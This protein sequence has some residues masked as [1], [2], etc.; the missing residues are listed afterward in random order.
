MKT[1]RRAVTRHAFFSRRG[2]SRALPAALGLVLLLGAGACQPSDAKDFTFQPVETTNADFEPVTFVT[3]GNSPVAIA[4]ADA[5][6][7]G[8]MDVAVINQFETVTE[9]GTAADPEQ[10]GTLMLFLND[11]T[12][13]LTLS[14]E[15]NAGAL[16]SR[17]LFAHLN[18][19]G[20]P[21]LAVLTESATE[22]KVFLSN[23]SGG[24]TATSY[25]L[26]G[27]A[28]QMKTIDLNGNGSLVQDLVVSLTDATTP[29]EPGAIVVLD[30]NGSGGFDLENSP[31]DGSS[32]YP[33]PSP[34]IIEDL[35]DDGLPDL[36][37]ADLLA[38]VV[39]IMRGDGQGGFTPLGDAL[40][41]GKA[42]FD[43][44][45]EDFTAD[46][47]KDIIL[48]ARSA[49][50]LW[51]LDGLGDGA[52]AISPISPIE[53]A[54]DSGPPERLLLG[55]FTE[56]GLDLL[57]VQRTSNRMTMLDWDGEGDFALSALELSRDP[58]AA[59]QGDF[60]RDGMND[61]I[62]AEEQFHLLSVN[63]GDG[64][65][66]FGRTVIGL[67][68][69]TNAPT[70]VDLDKDGGL[71][72]LFLQPTADQIGVLINCHPPSGSPCN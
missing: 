68:T 70:P 72:L 19:D 55:D 13:E 52:F 33:T 26:G 63:A 31:L 6:G 29:L 27:T 56:D 71:D 37:V 43:L 3:V 12:G 9:P 44:V 53:L 59:V 1:M 22:V 35:D 34:F 15:L 65:G 54:N 25:P 45:A 58:F 17:L 61:V 24:Y 62:T 51:L 41:V 67:D 48:T 21:D 7:D 10:P 20:L 5:D 66:H 11:G 57:V 40:A 14:K 18:G 39:V 2:L 28:S 46:G 49:G 60:N 69:A 50:R 36:A 16:P 47:I 38:D 64:E 32:A 4:T 23:G 30:N 8:D 42:P